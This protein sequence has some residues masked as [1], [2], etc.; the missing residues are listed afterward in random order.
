MKRFLCSGTFSLAIQLGLLSLLCVLG[1]CVD[2]QDRDADSDPAALKDIVQASLS[3]DQASIT[4][5][6][7]FTLKV[8]FKIRSPWHIYWKNPGQLGL[9]TRVRFELPEGFEAGEL[10]WPEP[11]TFPQPGNITGQGYSDQVTLASVIST[12]AHLSGTTGVLLKAKAKWL[13]CSDR[14]VPGEAD[15]KIE[16]PVAVALS[17]RAAGASSLG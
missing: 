17:M 5:G 10:Q 11:L 1:G 6:Q 9:P 13:A 7:P 2:A 14:C 3:T 16:V 8:N 4:P 15:L 12:P